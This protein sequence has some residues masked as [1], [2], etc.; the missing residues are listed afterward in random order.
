MYMTMTIMITLY[1]GNIDIE[2][3]KEHT[4][5]RDGNDNYYFTHT[6]TVITLN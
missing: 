5:D 6:Q 2:T 3:D 1:T 4:S